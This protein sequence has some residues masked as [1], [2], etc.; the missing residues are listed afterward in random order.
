MELAR[1]KK[2]QTTIITPQKRRHNAHSQHNDEKNNREKLNFLTEFIKTKI[3][4]PSNV[5]EQRELNQKNNRKPIYSCIESHFVFSLIW[6]NCIFAIE[7]ARNGLWEFLFELITKYLNEEKLEKG[8]FANGL[9]EKMENHGF[10][11]VFYDMQQCRWTLWKETKLPD[12]PIISNNYHANLEYSEMVRLNPLIADIQVLKKF[13]SEKEIQMTA[14]PNLEEQ[15]FVM[16][17]ITK[18]CKYFL[19]YLV[20]YNKTFLITSNSQAGK[21]TVIKYK[22]KKMLE[23]NI[24]KVI[25]LALTGNT[26]AETVSY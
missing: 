2:T 19:D 14:L 23:Q 12:Y 21:T 4:M 18:K 25:S 26:K 11:E 6:A 7:N 10:M 15:Q 5:I 3:P 22:I 9:I 20:G 8:V 16:N 1:F 17:D 24:C 13:M